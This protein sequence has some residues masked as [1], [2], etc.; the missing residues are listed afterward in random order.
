MDFKRFREIQAEN[1]ALCETKNRAYG[2]RSLK[3]FGALGIVVRMTDKVERLASMVVEN[4]K[5]GRRAQKVTDS[6]LDAAKDLQNYATMLQMFLEG[7]FDE[8]VTNVVE[9][10]RGRVGRRSGRRPARRKPRA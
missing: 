5:P 9:S 10:N 7:T 1:A 8:E 4:H 2:D 3:R 6:A